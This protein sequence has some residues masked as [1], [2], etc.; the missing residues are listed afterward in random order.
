MHR[1]QELH[2]EKAKYQLFEKKIIRA[3]RIEKIIVF[4]ILLAMI[5]FAEASQLQQYTKIS[6]CLL[7]TICKLVNTLQYTW[8]HTRRL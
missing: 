6:M 1:L 3:H 7:L 8:F 5:I 4:V 2:I